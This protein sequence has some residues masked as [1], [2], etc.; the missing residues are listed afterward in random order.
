M[1]ERK[2]IWESVNG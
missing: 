1:E 2:K